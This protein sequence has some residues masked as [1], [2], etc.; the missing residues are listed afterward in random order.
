MS[1]ESD[2]WS[3][4][5]GHWKLITVFMLGGL[6][7]GITLILVLPRLYRAQ[8]TV[9]TVQTDNPAAAQTGVARSLASIVGVGLQ[10]DNVREEA[11]ALLR[12]DRLTWEFLTTHNLLGLLTEGEEISE[13]DLRAFVVD[14]FKNGIL[15][16]Q[17][18]RRTGLITVSMLW[19]D[20][21]QAAEWANAYVR[22][23]DDELRSQTL[24]DSERTLDL[25]EVEL[26]QT[27][28]IEIQNA[29]NRF[30]ET[31]LQRMLFAR[32]RDAFALRT[33][34]PAIARAEGD[35]AAPNKPLILASALILGTLAGLVLAVMRET[36]TRRF[37][38]SAG[39]AADAA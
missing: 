14:R 11:L 13:D 6:V 35:T 1:H 34:D 3:V 15:S 18:D 24:K 37:Q 19:R 39:A 20:R 2:L 25:L 21:H 5:T 27:N 8:T 7:I 28:V 9:I 17:D 30:Y 12:S 10:Q 36:S 33:I 38:S 4:A 16:V 22:L 29:I 23:A 31:Q 32:A 26:E